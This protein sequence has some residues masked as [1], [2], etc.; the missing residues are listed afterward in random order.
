MKM[1]KK[2]KKNVRESSTSSPVAE[3]A[4][5]NLLCV[6]ET[7]ETLS[8]FSYGTAGELEKE[9]T[10]LELSTDVREKIVAALDLCQET[11]TKSKRSSAREKALKFVIKT[12]Q[13]EYLD[14]FIMERLST[15]V[16]VAEKS[17]KK[18]KQTEQ[19][20]G[21]HL[22]ALICCQIGDEF[23]SEYSNVL[24][25]LLAYIS[26][27]ATDIKV[28]SALVTCLGF[29]SFVCSE[30]VDDFAKV[31]KKL[32]QLFEQSYGSANGNEIAY[33]HSQCLESWSLLLTVASGSVYE[34]EYETHAHRISELMHSSDVNLRMAAGESLA[35][36]TEL[37]Q[38]I[39][40][41]F[42]LPNADDVLDQ[43]R[44]LAT[45]AQK[46]RARK[47]RKIQRQTFREILQFIED[48]EPVDEKI[49]ISSGKPTEKLFIESWRDKIRY[50]MFCR[51]LRIGTNVHL[52]SN[53][54]V[55]SVFDLGEPLTPDVAISKAEKA[56]SAKA[57]KL[58]KLAM[59][60]ERKKGRG[61]QRDLK[62]TRVHSQATE[63]LD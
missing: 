58:M 16:D 42:I 62:S 54:F 1:P 2:N 51:V 28:K 63:E 46:F 19:I 29:C 60:S 36:I 32:S 6:P 38:E 24:P 59:S 23:T 5:E 56:P 3:M 11:S 49:V 15:F 17:I 33:F 27:P 22:L 26:N 39:D 40:E 48:D 8:V 52:R 20:I 55:R 9:E 50:E 47:D 43:M 44:D 45:D 13:L 14:E 31:I 35:L 34:N 41:D 30:E 21:C 7:D 4:S 53:L 10:E 12:L 37:M 18:G 25:L 57:E 61:K